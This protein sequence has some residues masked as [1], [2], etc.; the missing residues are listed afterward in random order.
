MDI[1]VGLCVVFVKG[2]IVFFKVDK[3]GGCFF[4]VDFFG[5]KYGDFGVYIE[6]ARFRSKYYEI[7][8]L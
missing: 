6:V 7:G 3:M 2:F 8:V 1:K 4:D 5:V